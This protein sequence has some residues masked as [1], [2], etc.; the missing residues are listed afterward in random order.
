MLTAVALVLVGTALGWSRVNTALVQLNVVDPAG[1]ERYEQAPSK[2]EQASL[3]LMV[4][5]PDLPGEFRQVSYPDTVVLHYD[6]RPIP[7]TRVGLRRTLGDLVIGKV[8][9]F[10]LQIYDPGSTG[11]SSERL[12]VY[13]ND[14]VVW[15]RDAGMA[16][17]PGWQ[18]IYIDWI[19]R[20]NNVSI[21]VERTAG[22][23]PVLSLVSAPAVRNLHLYPTY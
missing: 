6:Q 7:G 20:S 1:W 19:A 8:Y 16:D 9:Q 23:T 21:R 12:T 3:P 22:T 14:E 4:I 18:V 2:E 17:E 13:L 10:Y 15:K 11:D 5:K